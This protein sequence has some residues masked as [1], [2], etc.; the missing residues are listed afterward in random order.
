MSLNPV[1]SKA[2]HKASKIVE[3]HDQY[4]R[5]PDEILEAIG[6]KGKM[7][8]L[9]FCDGKRMG[10]GSDPEVTLRTSRQGNI[11]KVTV[12]P[13][14]EDRDRMEGFFV[15]EGRAEDALDEIVEEANF[16]YR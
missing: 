15:S 9:R 12:A 11:Y 6:T 7:E 14:D 1:K 4:S 13:H 3:K 2:V 10:R 5:V 16:V 8:R